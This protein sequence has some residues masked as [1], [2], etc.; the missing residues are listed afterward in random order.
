MTSREASLQVAMGKRSVLLC[1]GCL[2][3]GAL[4]GWGLGQS[5]SPTTK[6]APVPASTFQL[7]A[8]ETTDIREQPPAFPSSSHGK[9]APQRFAVRGDGGAQVAIAATDSPPPSIAD[10]FAR[11][12]AGARFLDWARS[13]HQAGLPHCLTAE[14]APFAQA[15]PTPR[16]PCGALSES[17]W[18]GTTPQMTAVVR[19]MGACLERTAMP[20]SGA[21]GMI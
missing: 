6:L 17:L 2:V 5:S 20:C 15:A 10:C 7:P 4:G 14:S 3:L 19:A 13:V 21:Y 1:G 18:V 8:N 9:Q 11:S 16:E 12:V